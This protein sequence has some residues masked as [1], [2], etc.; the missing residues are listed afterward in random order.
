MFFSEKIHSQNP[1]G[2]GLHPVIG[3]LF[4]TGGRIGIGTDTPYK[5][6]HL[7]SDTVTTLRLSSMC[8]RCDTTSWD[9]HTFK[10]N[11]DFCFVNPTKCVPVMKLTEYGQL[12]LGTDNPNNSAIM[13]IDNTNKGLL[14]P[15]M[16]TNQK[17]AISS[18]ANG[19]L[20]YDTDL[21]AFSYYN[22]SSGTWLN[23]A[24]SSELSDYLMISDFNNS[25]AGG[26]M[27]S[28]TAN[29]NT[30]YN[31]SQNFTESDPIFTAWDKD[32]N[33][34]TNKPDLFDGNREN[35]SGTVPNISIFPNDVGYITEADIN[36][37]WQEDGNGN[38][39][40]ENGF[41]GIGVDSPGKSLD[42]YS[43]F[44]TAAVVNPIQRSTIRL[45]NKK[46]QFEEA[47]DIGPGPNPTPP[48]KIYKWDI[49]ND[50][51]SLKLNFIYYD[52]PIPAG[53]NVSPETKFIFSGDGTLQAAKFVGDGSGLMNVNM[54][55]P[56]ILDDAVE[57]WTNAGWSPR[58]QSKLGTVW[59]STDKSNLGN[60]YLGL[61]MTNSGWYFINRYD[62]GDYDYVAVIREDGRI[63]CKEVIIQTDEWRDN[64]FNKDYKFPTIEETEQFI[65]TYGHLPDIPSEKEITEN[66]METGELIKLQ[67]QKIEE[68]TL[69]IIE[70]NKRIKKLEQKIKK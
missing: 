33:D 59:A 62:N 16:T 10:G 18:P 28:D 60:Y 69:Y 41:V 20:V 65:N 22:I 24:I 44:N 32:Y 25:V 53:T 46:T 15:R 38:V 42:I 37:L 26:I 63:N 35:L 66:G 29:W 51:D 3:D 48:D 36:S 43:V 8:D 31:Y 12:Y 68:L 45:T 5:L 64:V 23:T 47:K 50:N 13:Q 17:N 70:Q 40:R 27:Q 54:N 14:I 4:H 58:L 2:K 30:A 34:L 1:I 56:I 67:M 11:L 21:K 55:E 39:Y 9:L 61:G 52:L 6:L 49:E 57:S 19:L 7:Y